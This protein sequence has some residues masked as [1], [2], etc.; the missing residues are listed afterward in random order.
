MGCL[1]ARIT[2][3]EIEIGS[4]IVLNHAMRLPVLLSGRGREGNGGGE[5]L[6][7]L[8]MSIRIRDK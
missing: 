8:E 3:G 6:Y 5:G 2:V 4:G 7:R 1:Q